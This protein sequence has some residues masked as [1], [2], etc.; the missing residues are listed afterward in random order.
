LDEDQEEWV[1]FSECVQLYCHRDDR[2]MSALGVALHKLLARTD[3]EGDETG[4]PGLS[5][6]AKRYIR[7]LFDLF[8]DYS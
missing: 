8:L 6:S 3:R 2:D 1:R 4:M 5:K 7:P